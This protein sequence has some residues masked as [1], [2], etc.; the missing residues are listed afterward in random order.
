[1]ISALSLFLYNAK[2]AFASLWVVPVSLAIVFFSKRIQLW[3]VGKQMAAK[4]ACADSIQE[5]LE[6]TRDL[7]A[8]NA[9][10]V[11]LSG[12][13]EKIRM[14]EKKSV[15]N[16]YLVG[17]FV[18]LIQMVLKAG[19][20]T[21]A[22]TGG[23]LLVRGEITLP[24]FILFLIVVSRLY[25][26]VSNSLIHLSAMIGAET[27]INRMREL[28]EQ[29]VQTGTTDFHPEN[30]NIVFDHVRFSYADG[31]VVLRDVSFTAR[32]G[33]VM[34]LMGPSGGKNSTVAR[35]AS[36]FWDAQKGHVLLGNTPVRAV[37]PET[38]LQY[39]SIVFQNV[40]LFNNSVM[41]NI[42][43]GRRGAT[44]NEVLEAAHTAQC[45]EFVRKLLQGY[46]TIIGENG[47]VLS[48]GERQRLSIARAIL[49][50]APVILLDE[51]TASLDME[52]ETKVQQALSK[53]I[54]GKNVLIIAHRMHTVSGA[55]HIIV[56]KNGAVAEDGTPEQLIEQTGEYAHMVALQR[57]DVQE[58]N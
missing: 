50:N 25:D 7:K 45:D 32:Q 16:E 41:E 1:V 55:D 22:F 35:L 11:Y 6:N 33:E 54:Q 13:D 28:D 29:P 24:L 43:I 39:F 31:T 10:I 20:A 2:L 46:Q 8:N 23:I 12:L 14:V 5:C 56:L 36:R 34:A 30:Y 44:D 53:L 9:E 47:A 27:N 26:P 42:R 3:S 57:M 58:V 52:N 4:L 18:V 37:E 38:L 21:T 40:T 19:V 49:K 15:R 51:A 48:G 17:V